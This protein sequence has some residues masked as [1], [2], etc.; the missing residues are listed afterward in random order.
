MDEEEEEG[1]KVVLHVKEAAAKRG[2][3]KGLFKGREVSS[4][5]SRTS[6]SSPVKG[7]SQDTFLFIISRESQQSAEFQPTVNHYA[8]V[9]SP[10]AP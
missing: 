10:G 1:K 7:S 3:K 5:S 2:E 4:S 8:I 9:V 6:P